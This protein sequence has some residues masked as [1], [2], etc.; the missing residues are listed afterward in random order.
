MGIFYIFDNVFT[1]FFAVLPLAIWIVILKSCAKQLHDPVFAPSFVTAVVITDIVTFIVVLRPGK[2]PY[3]CI[4]EGLFILCNVPR[5]AR[6]FGQIIWLQL[7][8]V[9]ELTICLQSVSGTQN[10]LLQPLMQ[11]WRWHLLLE[12]SP[13][14]FCIGG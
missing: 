1:I 12:L 14:W 6:R 8:Q 2:V 7:L 11:G 13:C 4:C 9:P 5:L 10:I 3:F